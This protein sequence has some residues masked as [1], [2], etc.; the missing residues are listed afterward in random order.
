NT[1]SVDK[2]SK[3]NKPNKPNKPSEDEKPSI[4]PTPP[5]GGSNMTN[6]D[7]MVQQVLDLVNQERA[8]QGLSSL[9]LDVTLQ[10]SAMAKSKDMAINNYFDHNSPTY[11]SVSNML[12]NFGIKWRANGENIA[13]GQTSAA[14]VM[15]SWM[16]S[17]GHRANILKSGFTHIG[18]GIYKNANGQ[19]LWTQQFITK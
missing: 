16:N 11:G 7:A 8:K 5:T 10:K 17:S 9:T 15:N 19:I 3:P 4:P 14:Q 12:N 6:V 2:P 1:P 18:I 13:K